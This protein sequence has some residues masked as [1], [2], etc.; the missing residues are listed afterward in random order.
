MATSPEIFKV[1]LLGKENIHCGFHL[2]NYIAETVVR[3]LPAATYFLLTDTRVANF[4]LEN[5]EAVFQRTIQSLGSKSRFLSR[6]IPPGETSKSREVKAS[7][8][9]YLL[10]EKCTRDTVLIVMGGG[11]IGDLGGFVA[12]TL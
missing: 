2:S 6:V 4:H 7:V 12:A 3:T 8:E 9:D 1:S 11:V 10:D 5:Y